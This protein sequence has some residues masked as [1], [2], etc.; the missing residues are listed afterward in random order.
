LALARE[1][2]ARQAIAIYLLNL[3]RDTIVLHDDS[4]AGAELRAGLAQGVALDI[5]ATV[6]EILRESWGKTRKGCKHT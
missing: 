2:G 1:L 6:E 3:A 4:A 5:D